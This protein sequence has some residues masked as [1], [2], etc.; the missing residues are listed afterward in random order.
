MS[1]EETKVKEMKV[2]CRGCGIEVFVKVERHP[3][4]NAIKRFRCPVC[5]KKEMENRR[6][7]KAGFASKTR[8]G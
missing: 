3:D 2:R 8:K 5:Y 7:K 6:Q 1:L 4:Q